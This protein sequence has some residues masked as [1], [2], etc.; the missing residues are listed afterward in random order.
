MR[1]HDEYRFVSKDGSNVTAWK[2]IPKDGL[3]GKPIKA[4]LRELGDDFGVQLRK[5]DNVDRTDSRA[6]LD[7]R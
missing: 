1:E 6:G 7:G 3:A 5:S 4:A 2:P